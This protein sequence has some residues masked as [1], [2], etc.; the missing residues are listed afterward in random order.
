MAEPLF[1]L[2]RVGHDARDGT[3]A[4]RAISTTI[5]SGERVVVLGPNGSGKSTLLHLLNGLV[6]P[7]TGRW[8]FRGVP[9]DRRRLRD[10]AWTAGLRRTMALMFQQ[11]EAM[12][13]NPTVREEI[14]FGLRHLEAADRDARIALWAQRL[15]LGDRL[16]RAPVDLSG[17]ER[18]RL[19]LAS[20][21]APEPSILLLDEPTANLDPPTTGWLLD[22][23]HAADCTT[24]T[25]THH[26]GDAAELG[27]RAL[28]LGHHH[29]LLHDGPLAAALADPALL[30]RAGLARR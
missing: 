17:G 28:I 15:G 5:D 24:I 3:P 26:L 25:A 9:V 1:R 8:W 18:Q 10:R 4:L 13:F 16:D 30:R 22:W 29:E 6:L 14:G 2:D 27:E 12:L 19:C 7:D 21:L 20:L 23:L 11:P